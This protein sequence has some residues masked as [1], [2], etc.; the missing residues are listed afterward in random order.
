MTLRSSYENEKELE[1]PKLSIADG[2][3]AM[4][5][6]G[7]FKIY[8]NIALDSLYIST[9]DDFIIYSRSAANRI[10][11]FIFGHVGRDFL[12]AVQKISKRFKVLERVIQVLHLL[13]C[14][15]LD[16]FAPWP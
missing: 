14:N 8:Y 3:G 9:I 6:A 11:V 2:V 15:P 13:F 5:G 12:I 1:N 4:A 10:N 16:I 7:N